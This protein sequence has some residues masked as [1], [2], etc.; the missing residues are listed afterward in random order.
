MLSC[1]VNDFGYFAH[2]QT[3]AGEMPADFV[4]DR[5]RQADSYGHTLAF[6]GSVGINPAGVGEDAETFH[7]QRRK[8]LAPISALAVVPA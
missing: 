1:S 8:R 4:R 7:I 3:F 6:V 2:H 5:V